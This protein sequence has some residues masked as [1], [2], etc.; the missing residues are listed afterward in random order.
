MKSTN[1]TN[2][3]IAVAPD[4]KKPAGTIP[5]EKTPPTVARLQYDLLSQNP[6]Q[7][8]SDEALLKIHCQR[9]GR[10]DMQEFFA[11]SQPCFRCSPLTKTYG[12]GIHCNAEGKMALCGLE[13]QEY[14]QFLQDEKLTQKA[15]M[16]SKR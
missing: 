8:T 11:K 15:G 2:T 4:S 9:K 3:F 13:S 5:P 16:A 7:Y 1:Y 10:T 6:Y 14:Q 12:W